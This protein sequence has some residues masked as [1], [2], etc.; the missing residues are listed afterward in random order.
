M[1]DQPTENQIEDAAVYAIVASPAYATD[2]TCFAA[3]AAGL[4]VS[5]DCAVTLSDA[6][7]ALQLPEPL[8]TPAVT[9]S[10]G[11]E[12]DGTVFAGVFGAILRSHD[13]GANW[14]YAEL[15]TP[16]PVVTCLA[17]SPAYEQDGIVFAGTLQDGIF[18]SADRGDRWAAWNFGLIDLGV[19]CL[20][21]SPAYA[22]DETLVVGTE[23]GLFRSTNGG[24]A[25]R[26]LGLP[27]DLAPV[28]SVA[29]APD[30]TKSGVL[31]AGTESSGLWVSSD[32]GRSWA[33]VEAL[34]EG[35]VN[36]LLVEQGGE[37]LTLVALVEDQ[38]RVSH[39]GAA[40]WDILPSAEDLAPIC[41]AAPLGA[42]RGAPLLVGCSDGALRQLTL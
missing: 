14:L 5:H 16:P 24:R 20:A 35:A 29:F 7:R 10:P 19:L 40:T 31:F 38:V 17:V 33:S 13:R 23:T 41:L 28:L 26:E 22:T 1:N 39:D 15:R 21:L 18:R 12:S 2:G 8:P 30:Y 9:L 25:W 42:A 36:A 27:T 32:R 3:T 6:Y 34:E 37:G 11:F 4:R